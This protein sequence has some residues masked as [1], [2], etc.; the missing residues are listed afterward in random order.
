MSASYQSRAEKKLKL[1]IN[2]QDIRVD[3]DYVAGNQITG[4]LFNVEGD[5]NLNLSPD[6]TGNAVAQI[7]YR[8]RW[9]P[10]ARKL[11]VK[12]LPRP[13]RGAIGRKQE[14][15]KL[16]STLSDGEIVQL[17]ARAEMG[18]TVIARL[19]AHQQHS[20]EDGI[21]YLNLLKRKAEDVLQAIFDQFYDPSNRKPTVEEIKNHIQDKR[22]LI[23]IDQL[24]LTKNEI[25]QIIDGA[26]QSTFLFLGGTRTLVGEGRP[27]QLRG[28]SVDESLKLYEKHYPRDLDDAERSSA[29]KLVMRLEGHPGDIIRAAVV[30]EEDKVPM[31]V[32]LQHAN[33]ATFASFTAD[34]AVSSLGA[35][36]GRSLEVLAAF[37]G[38]SL[39]A[40]EIAKITGDSSVAPTL[41]N[42]EE[43][44]LIKRDAQT[45]RYAIAGGLTTY[46][47]ETHA[48]W[49]QEALSYFDGWTEAA[50]QTI[51]AQTQSLDALIHSVEWGLQNGQ[52]T[53]AVSL[54][55]KISNTLLQTKR[56]G[57]G[58]QLL[59][60]TA[61][62]ANQIGNQ[63]AAAWALHQL[64]TLSIMG[65]DFG[66]ARRILTQALNIRRRLGQTAAAL[67]TL[68]H[69]SLLRGGPID[70]TDKDPDTG[71]GSDGG[72]GAPSG[73]RG[74]SRIGGRVL[75]GT[76][77]VG[78]IALGVVFFGGAFWDEEPPVTLAPP[79]IIAN[80][81]AAQ[82][83]DTPT[84]TP[85]ATQVA[86][87]VPPTETATFTPTNTPTA[88]PT[89]TPT[90]TAIPTLTPI[91]TSTPADLVFAAEISPNWIDPSGRETNESIY[92]TDITIIPRG[93]FEPYTYEFD[94]QTQSS[95]TFRFK[96]QAC[97]SGQVRLGVTSA[98]GQAAGARVDY[99]TPCPIAP[100]TVS[101]AINWGTE[102]RP[103][104]ST[105]PAHGSLYNVVDAIFAL[106]IQGGVEPYQVF[107]D[108]Q[109][110]AGPNYV[111]PVQDCIEGNYN[112]VILVV[113]AD[114]QQMKDYP[115][116]GTRPCPPVDFQTEVIETLGD[117]ISEPG[118]IVIRELIYVI[119]V[120]NLQGGKGHN[121][122]A[123]I[124]GFTQQSS[125]S[126][127]LR[128]ACTPGSLAQVTVSSGTQTTT[129]SV[130]FCPNTPGADE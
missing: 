26:P 79:T 56:W 45:G 55:Q 122:Q 48:S 80:A 17:F 33:P 116:G 67:L 73:G 129:K 91:P 86:E 36:S 18:K 63:S 42:L 130:D 70:P 7:D 115:S 88:T 118:Q 30:R 57:Y 66:D 92:E 84:H 28:L 77:V 59:T 39:S 126:F 100:L 58:R 106:N 41:D 104:P 124:P 93:G 94:G 54:S 61:N 46:H 108:D 50:G 60:Q 90:S 38:V 22:A 12:F 78:A 6:P 113:S 3:G 51:N 1:D 35:T 109:P 44:N 21:I 81:D 107:I 114:G 27:I 89:N 112:P 8:A 32:L 95:S 117:V 64:G 10:V 96:A 31:A 62:V 13:F 102:H 11:P 121:Y 52:G 49:M 40:D 72:G 53:Q 24:E 69:L 99:T 20:F 87:V 71:D 4:D 98:D 5:L 76:L 101:S 119:N 47:A 123:S 16:K 127:E 103:Q 19:L 82:A 83:A 37:G 29:K 105:N 65:K 97:T 9:I 15:S 74:R 43:R 68:Y 128:S 2:S 23:I 120:Y 125:Y 75:A 25:E 14:V 111:V 110:V 85:T 34:S